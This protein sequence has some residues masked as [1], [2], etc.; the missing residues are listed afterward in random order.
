MG[1]FFVDWNGF[2]ET[3]ERR[4]G[5][6]VGQPVSINGEIDFVMLPSP[7]IELS[8]IEIGD[9]EGEPMATI[10]H[11][12]LKVEL[13][14]L[15]TGQINVTELVLDSPSVAASVD[16]NGV[17]DWT[18]RQTGAG[19]PDPADV[20]LRNVTINNGSFRFV[21]ARTANAISL[22]QINT[23]LFEAGSLNG[24][25][26]IEGSLVCRIDAICGEALPVTFSLATGRVAADGSIRVTT[27]LTPASADLAGTLATEGTV[28]GLGADFSYEGTF[29]FDK[30]EVAAD[31][32]PAADGL[33]RSSWTIGG[34]FRFDGTALQLNGFTWES[35]DGLIAIVGDAS[36]GLGDEP[37][38]E[39][40]L[41]SRQ[42]DLD[43]A[44][45]NGRAT[46]VAAATDEIW[47]RL[48][49]LVPPE[50]PGRF[51]LEIPAVI[52]SGSVL[53]SVFLEASGDGDSWFVHSLRLSLPGQSE[54]TVA[55]AFRPA[56]D[57][58]FD[59]TISFRSELPSVLLNWLGA[60]SAPAADLGAI[61]LD[62]EIV[63]DL[64][65]VTFPSVVLGVDDR[66]IGGAMAWRRGET[67]NLLQADLTTQSF[68][69]DQL[70]AIGELLLSVDTEET[71]PT[72]FDLRLI[73]NELI[74]GDVA[75]GNV[76]LDAELAGGVLAVGELAVG[77]LGGAT[78]NIR[79][80]LTG[81]DGDRPTGTLTA[82]VDAGRVE[83]IAALARE[84]AGD[85]PFVGWLDAVAPHLAPLTLQADLVTEQAANR[86][87]RLTL[88]GLAGAT[89]FFATLE[90]NQLNGDLLATD[91]AVEI[92]ID[93]V[94]GAELAR[95]LGFADADI[96]TGAATL[97]LTA[98]GVPQNGMAAHL[99]A[100]FAGLVLASDGELVVAA[101]GGTRFAGSVAVNG[102]IDPL[103]TIIGLQ[104][105]N[106]GEPK[107]AVLD[108]RVAIDG[109]LTEIEIL[110]SSILQRSVAG[111]LTLGYGRDGWT[112][113]GALDLEEIDLAWLTTL[114][115]GVNPFPTADPDT[116]W[117]RAPF[118]GPLVA[119]ID[120]DLDL[121]AGRLL[122]ADE[123]AITNADIGYAFAADGIR[124][125][126]RNG[127]FL[128]GL[129]R[130]TIAADYNNGQLDLNGQ[131][132][133]AD[134]PLSALVWR[135]EGQ[136]VAEGVVT[137]S[138][139]FAASG[140][141]MAGL[142]S[143]LSGSGTL[144]LRQA[145]FHFL[146][147]DA[148]NLVIRL[149][150]EGDAPMTDDAL[151]EAFTGFLDTG[152]LT[153]GDTEIP[154]D[155]ANGVLTP[156]QI[157]KEV[158][159]V[160]IVARAP[161]DLARLQIDSSW[162]L[163][164]INARGAGDGPQ[165]RVFIG[166]AGPL[167]EPARQ[168]NI[169]PL[170]GFLRLRALQ[171]NERLQAEILERERFIRIIERLQADAAAAAA[172]APAPEPDAPEPE[173]APPLLLPPAAVPGAG[174]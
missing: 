104:L 153:F 139:Q 124:F 56:S 89:Q 156:R 57:T 172:A 11:L 151:R 157:I 46:T 47:D 29:T 126:L 134:V 111:N 6:I 43:N 70:R 84:F 96:E 40:A 97:D 10:D 60:D 88:N 110:P 58:P 79:G 129:A 50:I 131:L 141:S 99:Q 34:G 109:A 63:A 121:L 102:D 117:S 167:A 9:I 82:T 173:P 48:R 73:A 51:T 165:P 123:L 85:G 2:R 69:F 68:G 28:R 71:P 147:P 44:F 24:P 166:F 148:F 174:P 61:E 138:T 137:L 8:D 42:I 23:N 59:G 112:V 81:L 67:G 94:D 78:I 38:F 95:Q 158:G 15:L 105:P 72:R 127:S 55:G 162:E 163:T 168:V 1:P 118:I 53:P 144:E 87:Y 128:S 32:E 45:G 150:D 145:L 116:P 64:D 133:L 171:E 76:L 90:T 119:D 100:T 80:D 98:T 159:G 18:I 83:G 14:P 22:G 93:A 160:R 154:F 115:V 7:T 54:L 143:S 19:G 41:V 107:P 114:Q 5:D 130:G 65:A 135:S 161:V 36:L 27:E 33:L 169:A 31:G 108:G 122:I 106:P 39:A 66:V 12:S 30:L 86:S 26:R 77:D 37:A 74:A 3:F 164:L 16:D 101:E 62:L 170:A 13:L 120:V 146:R 52:V 103:A 140:R 17:L 21:D 92:A 136:P 75:I 4:A 49:S 35:A 20:A 152:A 25:W 91:A 125:E 155:I 142:I 132:F 113:R 149:A